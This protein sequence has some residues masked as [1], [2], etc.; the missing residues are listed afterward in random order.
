MDDREIRRGGMSYTIDSIR[1]L[2]RENPN[3][4]FVLILGADHVETFHQWKEYKK[5]LEEVDLIFTSRPG[6][7]IPQVS[8][9][10]PLFLKDMVL[11]SDFNFLELTTGR[12]IQFLTLKDIEISSSEL[13]KWLRSNRPVQKFLPLSVELYIKEKSLYRPIGDRIANYFDFAKF[14]GDSLFERKG[15]AVRGF[16]LTPISAPTEYAVVASG[17]STRHASSLAEHVIRSV[18]DEYNIL[19]QGVEGLDEGRWV[20]IDYGSLMVHVFYDFVR[21]E[22]SIEKLWKDG[23]DMGLVDKSLAK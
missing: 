12:N 18:K 21:Q 23:K 11:E 4:E 6:F 14:C 16:D 2:K 5:I 20:V 19:P 13:R 22:Y 7:D 3:A 8:E 1:E 15:I 17:T 10:I 9:E